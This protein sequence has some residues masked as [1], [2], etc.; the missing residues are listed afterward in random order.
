ML[1]QALGGGGAGRSCRTLLP[2][3]ALLILACSKQAT[4]SGDVLTIEDLLVDSNEIAG[5]S[6][7][8]TGWLATNVSELTI[9]IDGNQ[10]GTLDT[11]ETS[12]TTGGDGGYA[13]TDLVPAT[14]VVAEVN[15]SGWIQTHPWGA[16]T[17]AVGVSGGQVVSDIS[18]GNWPVPCSIK[19]TKW[20][21]GGARAVL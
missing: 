15:E 7:H 4:D 21:P 16:G 1:N 5:W 18:F 10:N 8:G 6:Y 20:Q 19:G 2:V 14:Y 12:T 9:Y 13:L 11:D 17:Y 3:L